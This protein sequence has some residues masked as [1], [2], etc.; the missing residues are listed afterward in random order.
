MDRGVYGHGRGLRLSHTT[1]R[2]Y[3]GMNERRPRSVTP[4]LNV[5]S[6]N[7]R[8]PPSCAF[9]CARTASQAIIAELEA[10]VKLRPPEAPR[11]CG[12]TIS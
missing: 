10:E 1:I 4:Y 7:G 12:C 2:R 6:L 5:P 8:T 9:A 11:C 3:V